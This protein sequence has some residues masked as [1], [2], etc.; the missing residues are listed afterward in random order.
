MIKQCS[1]QALSAR[2]GSNDQLAD[3]PA[4]TIAGG[5]ADTDR[6]ALQ[7][8]D[9]ASVGVVLKKTFNGGPVFADPFF[10]CSARNSKI[11]VTCLHA[12][13]Y[14]VSRHDLFKLSAGDNN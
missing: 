1:P 10:C 11:Q 12:A 9:Q 8:G 2:F 4:V 13:N 14:Q 6:P 5:N 7:F 3:K